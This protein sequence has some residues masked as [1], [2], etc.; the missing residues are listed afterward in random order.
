MDPI[1]V[2]IA[3]LGDRVQEFAVEAGTTVAQ[4]IAKAGYSAS[5]YVIKAN[6]APADAAAVLDDGD[7]VTLT[8]QVKGG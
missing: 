1:T 6:G 5:G 4:L 7:L 3:K 8:P 2:K